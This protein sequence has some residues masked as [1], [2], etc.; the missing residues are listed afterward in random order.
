MISVFLPH[1]GKSS[2]VGKLHLSR[3]FLRVFRPK[4]FRRGICLFLTWQI[5]LETEIDYVYLKLSKSAYAYESQFYEVYEIQ[6]AKNHKI[7]SSILFLDFRGSLV[8]E[9][10]LNKSSNLNDFFPSLLFETVFYS[11]QYSITVCYEEDSFTSENV[12]NIGA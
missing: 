8:F 7:R 10:L 3:L 9:F 6:L 2:I 12:G 1:M 5:V 11:N 4:K